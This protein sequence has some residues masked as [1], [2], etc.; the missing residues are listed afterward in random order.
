MVRPKGGGTSR[1]FESLDCAIINY[2]NSICLC[3]F[4]VHK[5]K[6]TKTIKRKYVN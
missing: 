5:L 2:S 1:T 3:T 4:T 6:K